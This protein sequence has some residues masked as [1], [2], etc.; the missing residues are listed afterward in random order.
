MLFLYVAVWSGPD[1]LADAD[2][3]ITWNREE[4]VKLR[5]SETGPQAQAPV[6]VVTAFQQTL[7]RFPDH[8]ALGSSSFFLNQFISHYHFITLMSWLWATFSNR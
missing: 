4:A 8:P 7:A 3:Y 1:V 6:S 5:T 2:N